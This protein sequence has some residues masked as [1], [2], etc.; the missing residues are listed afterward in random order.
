MDK[1]AV[2]ETNKSGAFAR[3]DSIH[4]HWIG[5]PT[6]PPEPQRYLLIVALACPWAHRCLLARSLLG[7]EE[8]IPLA[9]VHPTWQ[10]TKPSLDQHSGW[11][12]VRPTDPPVLHP[13]QMT[14]IPCDTHCVPPPPQY[15]WH[16]VRSIYDDSNDGNGTSSTNVKFTVPILWDL[17]LHRIVN[18][19]SSEILR[20]LSD[21]QLLGQFATKHQQLVLRPTLLS[22]RIDQVNEWVYSHINNG[23][24]KCGFARTQHAYN[25]A[26][27]ELQQGLQRAEQI[28][29]SSRYL[30]SNTQLTEA[31]I[32]LFVTLIRHDEVYCVYFKCNHVPIVG[33]TQFPNLVR[34][35]KE[36]MSIPEIR[37]TVQMEHIKNHYYT[38]HPSLN[39]YGIVPLGPNVMRSLL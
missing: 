34:Y 10:L 30:C 9:T 33:G 38:S 21:F 11:V 3:T 27:K 19:E 16:S 17:Q 13:S 8:A 5:S 12:F 24:Y 39:V 35:M 6:F 7:L 4:R 31:D 1:T 29:D 20:M 26:A 36:L 23:V 32:R 28:L 2:D 18:N 22:R 15:D 14:S 25:T 37:N